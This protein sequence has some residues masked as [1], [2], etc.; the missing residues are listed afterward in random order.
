MT[1][2][3]YGAGIVAYGA[4]KA[5]REL[6][7]M[8]VKGFIVTD[9]EG[10]PCQIDKVPVFSLGE[11][12]E[13]LSDSLIIIAVPAEYQDSI[14]WELIRRGM[15]HGIPFGYIKLDSHSE[16]ELMGRYLR[17]V[18][19]LSLIEDYE[20]AGNRGYLENI[21]IYM[22]VSH[23]DKKLSRR[24]EE[25]P[26]IQKIQVGAALTNVK[27]SE[28]TDQG[29]DSLSLK[30]E[31]YGELTATYYAWRYNRSAITGIF[32]Y[33]RVLEVSGEQ[34]YLIEAGM[35]DVILPLPF[36]C[37]PDASGQYGRYLLPQDIEIMERVLE[38][39]EPEEYGRLAAILKTP[40]L[41]NYNMLVA[42]KEVFD[43]YCSWLFPLL[44]EITDRCEREKRMRKPRYIGRIGEVLTSLYFMRNKKNWRITHGE[45]I[46]RV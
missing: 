25:E 43:D 30:N 22:A 6:F 44:E 17:K 42:R 11:C 2:Y 37:F 21:C 15:S 27:I 32:H 33:R 24:Y 28:A 1:M 14:E 18:L 7:G 12:E 19:K 9:K 31:L 16:Y 20:T 4:Y 36:V 10:Q 13:Q 41:Y 34:L 35:I 3:L 8:T 45:K 23:R 39:R 40:Y 38:E 5:I 46:W 26:W 29:E